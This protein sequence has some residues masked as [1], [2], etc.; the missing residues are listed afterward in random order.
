MMVASR[1]L[2]WLLGSAPV[3]SFLKRQIKKQPAGP[4]D[5]ERRE[6]ESLLWGEVEDEAGEKRTS[7][8]RGPEGYTLTAMTSLAI[9]ERVLKG[10][11]RAGFSTPSLAY[12]ADFITEMK[13]VAREDLS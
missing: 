12:G 9:A 11:F 2:G 7:R 5:L 13:G 3:Q 10:D 6:S 1:Y 8:L 4:T